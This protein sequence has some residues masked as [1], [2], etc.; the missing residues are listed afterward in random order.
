[1]ISSPQYMKICL[2]SLSENNLEENVLLSDKWWR[3]WVNQVRL[4]QKDICKCTYL[5]FWS[6]NRR[7]I[8]LCQNEFH[9]KDGK[10]G[11]FRY[12]KYHLELLKKEYFFEFNGGYM[13]SDYFK[14]YIRMNSLDW[15]ENSNPY[16]DYNI[17]M[18]E[19]FEAVQGLTELI[20]ERI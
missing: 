4:R 15:E 9:T 16:L 19:E 10:P 17:V 2:P 7:H 6:S 12:C 18:D 11:I 20:E 1:M 5:S 8:N 14:D 3:E 13:W